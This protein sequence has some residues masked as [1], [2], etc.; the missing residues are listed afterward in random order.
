M[1]QYFDE[2]AKWDDVCPFLLNDATGAKTSMISDNNHG[3][4][5]R[6]RKE[7]LGTF[8]QE[9]SNPTWQDVVNALRNGKYNNL[10][11]RIEGDL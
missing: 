8:L 3:N 10:A 1:L 2:V 5:A 7:M 9:I 6:C 11:D 4:V